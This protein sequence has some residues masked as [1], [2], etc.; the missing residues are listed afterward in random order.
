MTAC[1][2]NRETGK[3]YVPILLHP[4]FR[5]NVL[6]PRPRHGVKRVG[7]RIYRAVLRNDNSAKTDNVR[8]AT[9]KDNV[10]TNVSAPLA[11]FIW[12]TDNIAS[13]DFIIS[14]LVCKLGSTHCALP[15]CTVCSHENNTRA[16]TTRLFPKAGNSG[17]LLSQI[18]DKRTRSMDRRLARF[19][20]T[21]LHTCN[22][23][24]SEIPAAALTK[25][26]NTFKSTHSLLQQ[27]RGSRLTLCTV[28]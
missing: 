15:V 12:W 27:F 5:H 9:W 19:D 16:K 13:Y 17:A 23:P 2:R 1:V 4:L 26:C 6:V 21:G 14:V 11:S 25:R 3:N 22:R 20:A 18:L 24:G 8:N 7:L 28:E 10:R